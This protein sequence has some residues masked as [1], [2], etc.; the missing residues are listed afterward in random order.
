MQVLGLGWIGFRLTDGCGLEAW[1]WKHG[2]WKMEALGALGA[3]AMHCMI[4]QHHTIS[5]DT[6]VM[7][8]L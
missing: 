3:W 5:E 2:V 6:P 4:W 7:N 1:D 8:N